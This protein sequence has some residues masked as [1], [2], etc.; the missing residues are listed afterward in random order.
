[1]T[2]PVAT[3]TPDARAAAKAR[4]IR[5]AARLGR[6]LLAALGRSWRLELRHADAWRAVKAQGRPVVFALWH[7]DLLPLVWAHR[8]QG[9]R[10]LISEHADGEIIARVCEAC[11]LGAVRGSTSRGAARALLQLVRELGA[12]HDLAVTPD[13]PRGPARTVQPGVL[14]AA[15]RGR[16]P[17]VP[18]A[19]RVSGAWRLRS[20]DRFLIPTPFARVVVAYGDPVDVPASDARAAAEQGPWLTARLAEAERRAE[21]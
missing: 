11:G 15:H 4:R 13:G 20:W 2:H 10:V 21:G 9:V 5:W 12:G 7:G 1:M 8:D 17:I 14:V 18:I 16:A 6:G 3:A 19:V